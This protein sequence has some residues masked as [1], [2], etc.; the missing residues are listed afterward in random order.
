M[1]HIDFRPAELSPPRLREWQALMT[2][3][4]AATDDVLNQWRAWLASPREKPF[5]PILDKSVWADI[6]A[7]VHQHIFNGKCAYCETS[8]VRFDFHAEHYRPKGAVTFRHRSK[9][10]QQRATCLD[11]KGVAIAHPGYFWL[12]YAWG[13]LVPSCVHCNTGRGKK[14]QFPVKVTH[15]GPYVGDTQHLPTEDE[16]DAIESPLLL[17]PYRGE[18]PRSH[19]AFDEHGQILP[20]GGSERGATSI[21]VLN[22]DDENLRIDRQKEQEAVQHEFLFAMAGA[23]GLA[24]IEVADA[25][26]AHLA[27]GERRYSAALVDYL[28][29]FRRQFSG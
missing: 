28:R 4:S 15:L 17:H 20:V 29:W 12:A 2:R 13:N 8:A 19:L 11:D 16:L 7:W 1:I 24:A 27:R 14:M 9:K 26:I 6:K 18:D 25:F 23:K 22:L 10:K 21:A 3:A 5:N